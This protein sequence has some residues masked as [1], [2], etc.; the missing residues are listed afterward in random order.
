M[1]VE[2]EFASLEWFSEIFRI[3]TFEFYSKILQVLLFKSPA[4]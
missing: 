2:C 3:F 1:Y 4:L